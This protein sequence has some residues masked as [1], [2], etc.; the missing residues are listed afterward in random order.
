MSGR[1]GSLRGRCRAGIG[2]LAVLLALAL[3]LPAL[4]AACIED[5]GGEDRGPLIGAA[6]IAP[7][8]F[9]YEGGTAVVSAEVEDDCGIQRVWAEVASTEGGLAW[10][11]ALL[12]DKV[13]NAN[14]VLYRGEVVLPPNYQPSTARYLAVIG[15]EDTNGSLEGGYAGEAEVEAPPPFDEAPSVGNPTVA[16]RELPASGGTVT[17]A[18]DASDDR[19]LADVYAVVT[20]PDG[21]TQRVPLEATGGS[22]FEGAYSAP[23][24]AG[25]GPRRY[26]IAIVAEDDA[27]QTATADAGFVTVAAPQAGHPPCRGQNRGRHPAPDPRPVCQ[28]RR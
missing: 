18:A 12:P 22:H 25:A 21:Q 4:A 23:A 15:A 1:N 28:P 13:V 17:I 20:L 16:P 11:F 3:A 26:A 24:N 10:S 27:G 14:T 5:G 19:A 6:Q 9:G 8:S 2:T 7:S